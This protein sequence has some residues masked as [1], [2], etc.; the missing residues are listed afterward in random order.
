MRF[1]NY[2]SFLDSESQTTNPEYNQYINKLK[3]L[4]HQIVAKTSE[5][6]KAQVLVAVEDLKQHYQTRMLDTVCREQVMFFLVDVAKEMNP[7]TSD[8][9]WVYSSFKNF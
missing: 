1:T 4:S 2:F 3:D 6:S 8:E 9:Y 7:N 5:K